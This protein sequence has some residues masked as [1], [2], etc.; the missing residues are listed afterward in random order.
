MTDQE[1]PSQE[2]SE[3]VGQEPR[4]EGAGKPPPEVPAE[5]PFDEDDDW[6]EQAEELP[7]RPR[8]RLLAPLPV[9]LLVVL[10]TACGF[11]GGVLAEKGQNA[12]SSGASTAASAL[13][14]RFAALRSGATGAT[15]SAGAGG[16]GGGA[17]GFFG[18]GGGGSTVGQ[19][20]FVQNGTLYVTNSEG[21]TI[22]VTA[23]AGA[24]VT[25][26][27][28][29]SLKGIHP[30][31]T[32][33]VRGTTGENGAIDAESI[34][35]GEAEGGGLAS[36]FGAGAG[37]GGAASSRSSSGGSSSSSSGGSGEPALFGKGGG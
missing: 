17:G 29:S 26:T 22:K 1:Y 4:T 32:V 10:M 13:A 7:G 28:K 3:A 33:V 5:E 11:I 36:L 30:G 21:N 6:D 37:A 35:V 2:H 23:G 9:A 34:R 8:R 20:S 25:K 15:G 31:E 24:T 12:S 19:V 14:S 18:A 16:L 27:T